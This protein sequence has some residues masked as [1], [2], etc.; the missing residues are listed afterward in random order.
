M[1]VKRQVVSVAEVQLEEYALYSPR[2]GGAT[3]L[4]ADGAFLLRC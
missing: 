3:H 1:K 4:S 2:F